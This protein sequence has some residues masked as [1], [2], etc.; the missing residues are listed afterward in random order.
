[1]SV[2]IPISTLISTTSEETITISLTVPSTTETVVTTPS[3][4]DTFTETVSE[5]GK[6]CHC[7]CY[8][9]GDSS[10]YTFTF[11]PEDGWTPADG[12]PLAGA[13]SFSDVVEANDDL[14]SRVLMSNPLADYDNAVVHNMH[15]ATLSN[16]DK[17]VTSFLHNMKTG[18]LTASVNPLKADED[19]GAFIQSVFASMKALTIRLASW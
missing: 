14:G 5:P 19:P 8:P 3:P 10:E 15:N 1:M 17:L 16:D 6:W 4:T 2:T 12:A 7:T 11:F 9:D 13:E 18:N